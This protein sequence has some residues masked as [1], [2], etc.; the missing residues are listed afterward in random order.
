MDT[1]QVSRSLSPKDYLT[2]T[3]NKRGNKK[4]PQGSPQSPKLESLSNIIETRY[5][6]RSALHFT[7]NT[8]IEDG[9]N[10]ALSARSAKGSLNLHPLSRQ[11]SCFDA[12][13]NRCGPQNPDCK[14]GC[15][16]NCNYNMDEDCNMCSTRLNDCL[17]RCGKPDSPLCQ[18]SC[19][20]ERCF[21]GPK[22]CRSGAK[23]C[24][25]QECNQDCKP[26]SSTTSNCI[27]DCKKEGFEGCEDK[28]RKESCGKDPAQ[29]Q[30][31]GVCAENIC[32]EAL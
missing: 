22:Q 23:N 29:C 24:E 9:N 20:L 3:D 16:Q 12:C 27:E 19:K 17:N 5:H 14:K 7:S 32:Y 4:A 31:G 28:C 10:L 25:P 21:Q 2:E 11:S 30:P 15:S 6:E 8:D 26:C 13:L 18:A 1:L